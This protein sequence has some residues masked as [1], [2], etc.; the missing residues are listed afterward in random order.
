MQAGGAKLHLRLRGTSLP[1]AHAVFSVKPTEQQ[2]QMP[3]DSTQI[4]ALYQL[5]QH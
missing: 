4:C 1:P 3:G 5:S 2:Q